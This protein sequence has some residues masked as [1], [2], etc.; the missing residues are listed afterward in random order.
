MAFVSVI[1]PTFNRG[2]VLSRA[3]GSVLSQTFEDYELIVVDDG[4]TDSTRDLFSSLPRSVNYINQK[5]KGVSAARN[6]GIL[7]STGELVAFL[8]SDDEW[9]ADKLEKQVKLYQSRDHHF[10]CHSNEIWLR[11]G[12]PVFQ[13]EIHRKQ[14]GHFFERALERCLISPSAVIM[15]RSLLDDTGYFDESLPAAEDYDLWL[16][17]TAYNPVKFLDDPLIIKHGDRE[18]QLSRKV[19]A[20]DR[21][22]IQAIQKILKDPMLS[23]DYRDAAVRQLVKKCHIVAKGLERRGRQKEANDYYALARKYQNNQ[24]CS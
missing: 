13:K 8:D 20:I 2:D 17:I 16:R 14:G 21:F 22:R 3:I 23:A 1:V 18:D 15:T 10:I 19:P 12:K 4:S 24:N 7:E 11:N 9:C 6:K 5:H